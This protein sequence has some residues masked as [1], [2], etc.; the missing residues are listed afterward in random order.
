MASLHN[1]RPEKVIKAF[2]F[3]ALKILVDYFR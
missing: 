1:L 2:W 3:L